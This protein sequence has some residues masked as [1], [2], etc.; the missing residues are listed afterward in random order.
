MGLVVEPGK[1]AFI[2]GGGGLRGICHAAV[3]KTAENYGIIPDKIYGN[4]V[5]ALVGA[6]FIA[7]GCRTWP[8]LHTF[9]SIRKPSHVFKFKSA[10]DF[11]ANFGMPS[12]I[13]RPDGL[14]KLIAKINVEALLSKPQEFIA[15]AT[16]IPSGKV[17]YFST[18]DPEIIAEPIKLL[19]AIK[20]SAS[21]IGIFEF[22]VIEYHGECQ[23]YADGAYKRPL[24]IKKAIEDG[25]NTIVVS[26]CHSD[27]LQI[28]DDIVS[29][30]KKKFV[31]RL[32]YG[33]GLLHNAHE[34]DEIT[35]IR[36]DYPH[37]NLIVIE[38]DWLPDTLTMDS[39]KH[40]DFEAVMRRH[41][42]IAERELA[43]LRDYIQTKKISSSEPSATN[44]PSDA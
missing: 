31:H 1:T 27:L 37:V 5:G 15:V 43:P 19:M 23:V 32:V 39:G 8:L 18:R 33:F 24:P 29:I 30:W 22:E 6:S 36:K 13:Y 3:L 11:I 26:R 14:R 42:P 28:H 12:V 17:V 40:G 20:A 7:E 41:V 34:K 16:H 44:Q 2:L 38:P 35:M 10:F 9:F 21:P 4:S 25:C